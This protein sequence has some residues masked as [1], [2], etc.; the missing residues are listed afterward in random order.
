MGTKVTA[1]GVCILHEIIAPLRIRRRSWALRWVMVMSCGWLS[2]RLAEETR[3]NGRVV[4]QL[5]D[6]RRAAIAHARPQAADH[7]VDELAQRAAVRHAAL[8]ALGHEFVARW[9][10]GLWP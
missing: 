2:A 3:M 7:L 9:L 6:G 1:V 10:H 4:P 8:D 5:L